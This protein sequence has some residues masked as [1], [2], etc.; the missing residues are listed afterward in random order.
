MDMNWA[1]QVFKHPVQALAL[2]AAASPA[3]WAA[4]LDANLNGALV[5]SLYH[6]DSS[7]AVSLIN[8]GADPNARNAEGVP[9]LTLAVLHADRRA[10]TKLIAGGADVNTRSGLGRTALIAAASI[11]GNSDTVWLLLSAGADPNEAATTEPGPVAFVSGGGETPLIESAKDLTGRSAKL[12]LDAGAN[13][14]GQDKMGNSALHVAAFNGNS[15]VV[16][17]LLARH[18]S[19]NTANKMGSTPTVNAS[20]RGDAN[21]VRMLIDAGADVNAADSSESTAL[22]WAAYKESG[23]PA[24]VDMLLRAG[25]KAEAKNKLFGGETAMTWALRNGETP[26]VA[27]LRKAGLEGTAVSAGT[28]MHEPV[29]VNLAVFRAVDALQ[30]SSPEFVKNSPCVSCHHQTLAGMATKMAHDRGVAVNEDLMA[31]DVKRVMGFIRPMRPVMIENSDIVP[32]VVVTGPYFMMYFADFKQPNEPV[33]E[34]LVR[35]IALHQQVDGHWTG[36]A[37]RTPLEY[38]DIQATAL[39][40]RA[41]QL[42]GTADRKIEYDER[43]ARASQWLRNAKAA[44]EH[45]RNYQLLGLS[46]SGAPDSVVESLGKEI[47]ASQRQDGGWAQLRTLDSDAYATGQTLY[48]LNEACILAPSDEAYQRGV[49]FLLET[50]FD[51]GSWL[52]KTRAFPFQPLK[53]SKFPHGRDQW[54]S[55]TGTSWA[56]MALSLTMETRAPANAGTR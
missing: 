56:A 5:E 26:I 45:E 40:I 21:I 17:L 31:K 37:P 13:P 18:A 4:R 22:M 12:L 42:Y 34:A 38:G 27:R 15:E 33:L 39:S 32:D 20:I 44:G 54:I 41:L 46:W 2:L 6:G 25:A 48:V 24:V 3:G 7:T 11:P 10:V 19:V 43:I 16:R 50:Q 30:K 36:W 28:P 55:A 29:A 1:Q 23:D 14:N 49:R 51:D 8:R 47:L 9:A 52:V 35:N 53:D